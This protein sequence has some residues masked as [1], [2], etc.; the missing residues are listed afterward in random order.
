M[1]ES[2]LS[3]EESLRIIQQMIGEAKREQKDNGIGWIIWGWLLFLA[4]ILSFLNESLEWVN[5]YFF[6]NAFGII[7]LVM[8]LYTAIK[9]FFGKTATRVKTYTSDLFNRLN[10]G[11]FISL[12]TIIVAMNLVLLKPTTGFCLLLGL[13]GFW[14]LIYGTIFKFKPSIIGSYIT[15]ACGLGG[16]F[17][18]DYKYIMLIHAFGVLAGYIIPGHL[19]M[20]EFKRINRQAIHV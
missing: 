7:T 18:H 20:S 5:Q 12:M 16:L 1:E 17:V 14:I 4:S 15:S 6:W 10:I 3:R 13:Y 11:F 8:L 19:A 2:K 9:F